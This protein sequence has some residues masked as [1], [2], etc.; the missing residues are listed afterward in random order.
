MMWV[1]VVAGCT[2]EFG[3]AVED[4]AVSAEAS[5][6]AGG[7]VPDLTAA[8]DASADGSAS[9]LGED[10]A[11]VD[12]N[13][14]MPVEAPIPS[15]R[16]CECS[17]A[18]PLPNAGA[19]EACAML[20]PDGA[21]TYY[22]APPYERTADAE[23]RD[24]P[25]GTVTRYE[26]N[27][28][29]VYPGVTYEYWVYVPAQYNAEEPAALLVL[30]DGQ[31]YVNNGASARYRTPTVL[32]NLIAEGAM[33]VTVAVFIPPGS[34]DAPGDRAN[35]SLEYNT[36]DD[37][38]A[39]FVHDEIL[40]RVEREVTLTDEPSRRAIGGRSSGAVAAFTVAWE[41]P[42]SFGLVYTTIGSWVDL[43]ANDDG[44]FASA[45]P[46]WIEQAPR[47]NIRV[48]LLSGTNDLDNQFGNWRDAH[49]AMTTALDCAG[50]T[51][52]SGFGE[53]AHGDGT[54]IND[55]FGDDLRWLFAKTVER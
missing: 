4:A 40:P 18:M 52:L 47:K 43:R 24:N 50:Y 42:D 12:M 31:V 41:R 1:L 28:S 36:P 30:T 17:R 29:A 49:M 46:G 33:P 2:G 38:Y 32:D 53:G 9:D 39:R 20:R 16:F 6:D 22:E 48:T 5:V 25:R 10:A 21:G 26:W 11:V 34:R 15:T 19:F 8:E 7:T 27:D 44:D 55:R 35:R 23:D 45:Y 51:Y 14:D 54:H 37:R 13:A 3:G